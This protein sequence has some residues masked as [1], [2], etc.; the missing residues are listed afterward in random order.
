MGVAEC[1]WE[2]LQV[3]YEELEGEQ[4][5]LQLIFVYELN[6]DEYRRCKRYVFVNENGWQQI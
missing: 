2:E 6:I 4:Y 1:L 5:L 3:E